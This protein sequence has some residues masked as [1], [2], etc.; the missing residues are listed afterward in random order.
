M[1][2]KAQKIS[3]NLYSAHLNYADS[4]VSDRQ[5]A[6]FS[7]LQGHGPETQDDSLQVPLLNDKECTGSKA[8]MVVLGEES[9]MLQLFFPRN[10]I[11]MHTFF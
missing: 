4:L 9:S 1:L 6:Q 3:T 2:R 10:R 7:P 11:F 8:P 5:F